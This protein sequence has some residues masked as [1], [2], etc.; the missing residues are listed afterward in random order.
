MLSKQLGLSKWCEEKRDQ[1]QLHTRKLYWFMCCHGRRD[2]KW[3]QKRV[4]AGYK[5][6]LESSHERLE[7]WK[8]G[9]VSASERRILFTKWLGDAWEDYSSNNQEQITAAF[10][11][12]GMYNDINGR[13]N[14]LVSVRKGF[15]Y[16]VPEKDSP[17]EP[18]QKKKAKR[19]RKEKPEEKP[20][21]KKVKRKRK[22]KEAKKP[23][24]RKRR[25]KN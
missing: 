3:N 17:P 1:T 13:E 11:R 4:V 16:T 6:D 7:Q 24:K 5:K 2:R 8:N 21:K 9:N 23:R 15:Q 12:C 19:K 10:K 22:A 20:K 14:H 25:R 18:V